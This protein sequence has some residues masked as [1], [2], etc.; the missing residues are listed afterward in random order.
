M[1]KISI[2]MQWWNRWNIY[3]PCYSRIE[4][5][6]EKRTLIL[7]LDEEH[8][9]HILATFS[10]YFTPSWKILPGDKGR[11][12]SS[13]GFCPFGCSYTLFIPS[14]FNILISKDAS[15]FKGKTLLAK[16]KQK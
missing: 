11:K 14:H 16:S 3:L 12:G 9:F 15:L 10:S 6:Q 8:T 7:S 2:Y 1:T 5:L 4:K 13:I